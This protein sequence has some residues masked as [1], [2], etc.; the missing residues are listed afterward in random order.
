MHRHDRH[1]AD[2]AL[3]DRPAQRR[4]NVV[5]LRFQPDLEL[6]RAATT[7]GGAALIAAWALVP[8]LVFG[9]DPTLDPVT[10]LSSLL[11]DGT[12]ETGGPYGERRGPGV[13]T[14]IDLVLSKW[15]QVN[16]TAT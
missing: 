10:G 14:Y 8:V 4:P 7:L 12:H 1:L 15:R 3:S 5:A 13:E 16:R 2:A 9:T 11:E 6:T